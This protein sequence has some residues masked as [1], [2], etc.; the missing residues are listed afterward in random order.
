MCG[1]PRTISRETAPHSRLAATQTGS[2]QERMALNRQT[3]LAPPGDVPRLPSVSSAAHNVPPPMTMGKVCGPPACCPLPRD[4]W[5]PPHGL[6]L[7][8]A[9]LQS[10]LRFVCLDAHRNV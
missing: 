9:S 5:W 10:V 4:G 2:G 3:S 6:F 8:T 1:A 7:H